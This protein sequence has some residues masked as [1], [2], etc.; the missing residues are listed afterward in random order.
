MIVY[1]K[2][3]KKELDHFLEFSEKQ[4]KD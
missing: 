2:M 3:R 1:R 4:I